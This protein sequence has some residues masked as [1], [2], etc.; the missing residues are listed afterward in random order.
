MA[1]AM[2][3]SHAGSI[4]HFQQLAITENVQAEDAI[5]Y[6]WPTGALSA[7]HLAILGHA[8][9]QSSLA[10]CFVLSGEQVTAALACGMP[11]CPFSLLL[12]IRAH[13]PHAPDPDTL[14]PTY[15][16]SEPQPS[17]T[18]PPCLSFDHHT[19]AQSCPPSHHPCMA[20]P[21]HTTSAFPSSPHTPVTHSHPRPCTNAH[22]LALARRFP[23]VARQWAA[24]LLHDCD[25][26]QQG[27]DLMGRDSL[28]LGRMLI[29][30]V[31]FSPSP[32]H[33]LAQRDC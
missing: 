6:Y 15:N 27:V 26:E 4:R 11:L 8:I 7:T 28:L 19:I 30:L 13:P 31:S 18:A 32:L 16:V 9:V 5:V 25:V 20:G 23:A 22:L 33:M 10:L 12:L 14:S 29:T 1:I 21:P 17:R 24:A 2:R 3:S